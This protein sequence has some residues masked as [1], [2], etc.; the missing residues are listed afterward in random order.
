MPDALSIGV[1]YELFMHLNPTKLKPFY[2][3]HYRKM[4]MRDEEM[5]SV[6]GNYMISSLQVAIDRSFNGRKSKS[7]F[8]E[9]P[10]LSKQNFAQEEFT[11]EELQRQREIFVAKLRAM[12]ANFDI[13]HKKEGVHDGR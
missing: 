4:K 10:I 9:Y 5:W 12:K 2:E 11:E 7:K 1:S 3:A 8:I 6:F 13:N